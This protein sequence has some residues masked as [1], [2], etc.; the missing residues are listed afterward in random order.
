MDNGLKTKF[1]F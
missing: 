1:R